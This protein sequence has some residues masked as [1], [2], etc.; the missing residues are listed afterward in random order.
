MT[1]SNI[2]CVCIVDSL[3]S[4]LIYL[5]IVD[6]ETYNNTFYFFDR[7]IPNKV[8][9]RFSHFEK[10][11]WPSNNFK[12]ILKLLHL[13]ISKSWK[14]PFLKTAQIYCL[15]NLQ[16]TSA[17]VGNRK[18]NVLEDGVENYTLLRPR[19][20][21]VIKRII[22]GPLMGKQAFGYSDAVEKIYLTGLGEVP[23]SLKSKTEII[24]INQ[25]WTELPSSYKRSILLI[26]GLTEEIIR[27]FRKCKDILFTQPLSED[28]AITETEKICL[29]KD[30]IDGRDIAIKP[31]PREK[32]NY[33]LHLGTAKILES[34]IPIELLS[35]VG[36]RF[37]NVYTIFSTAVLSF[38]YPVNIH[39]LGTKVHPALVER[40]GDVKYVDGKIVRID[41]SLLNP[42]K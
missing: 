14:Y 21:R 22:G 20:H 7:N 42:S 12:K 37:T 35:F 33:S 41:K 9:N 8:A 32:T 29:Y 25:R 19:T 18:V 1:N 39:V 4:L 13:R 10:F 27:E 38:P 5:L 30:I 23:N 40:F 3:Y 34:T 11:E 16:L 15:D 6:E 31:H 26:Y 17:L 24:D 36:V 28:D 2:R